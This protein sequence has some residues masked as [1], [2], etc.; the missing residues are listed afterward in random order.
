MCLTREPSSPRIEGQLRN[1]VHILETM[2]DLGFIYHIDEPSHDEPFII[3]V[4]GKDFVASGWL[5]LPYRNVTPRN[6]PTM[7]DVAPTPGL[8]GAPSGVHAT[9]SARRRKSSHRVPRIRAQA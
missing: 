4:R 8:P 6:R 9:A 5:R 7:Y 1:S 2:Q 3:P